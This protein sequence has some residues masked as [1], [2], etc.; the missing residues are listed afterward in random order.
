MFG[1]DLFS[2]YHYLF[3][4]ILL[5]GIQYNYNTSCFPLLFLN[6]NSSHGILSALARFI[7][8]LLH[9]LLLREHMEHMYMYIHIYLLNIICSNVDIIHFDRSL[10]IFSNFR[11]Y[12]FFPHINQDTYSFAICTLFLSH[13]MTLE[14]KIIFIFFMFSVSSILFFGQL[15]VFPFP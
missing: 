3:L 14:F 12:S 9:L 6:P 2:S 8:I 15:S 10:L 1:H 5:L 11:I 13:L 4:K 7:G